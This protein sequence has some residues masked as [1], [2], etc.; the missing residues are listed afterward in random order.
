MRSSWKHFSSVSFFKLFLLNLFQQITNLDAHTHDAL[1]STS[2]VYHELKI[3]RGMWTLWSL[4]WDKSSWMEDNF[5]KWINH[6]LSIKNS[7]INFFNSNLQC[8][9]M[10]FVNSSKVF[11]IKVFC[12]N[13]FRILWLLNVD[14][15]IWRR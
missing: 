6:I 11:Y 7:S 9:S 8:F 3:N 13:I 4:S 14:K 5:K 1:Q 12:V 2:Q 10:F 15:I